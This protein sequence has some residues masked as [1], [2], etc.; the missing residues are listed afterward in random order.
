MKIRH[1]SVLLGLA[2]LATGCGQPPLPA[3]AVV[4]IAYSNVDG[5]DGFSPSA[6][7]LIAKLVDTSGDSVPSAG[8]TVITFKY[9]L[10]FGVAEFGSF[11][12]TQHAVA[13]VDFSSYRQIVVRDD[14]SNQYYFN[15]GAFGPTTEETYREQLWSGMGVLIADYVV[16]PT[17]ESLIVNSIAP[18][19]PES[20]VDLSRSPGAGDDSF[21]DVDIHLPG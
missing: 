15:S 9:P 8:D 14:E 13:S 20:S 3:P 6:D 4:A 12:T 5:I 17:P 1:A 7:V 11:R 19:A 21:I 18:S 16:G 2:V 10:A